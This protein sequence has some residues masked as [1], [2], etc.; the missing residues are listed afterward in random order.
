MFQSP[1]PEGSCS[2]ALSDMLLTALAFEAA[3]QTRALMHLEHTFF[4]VVPIKA[5]ILWFRAGR[6]GVIGLWLGVSTKLNSGDPRIILGDSFR[7]CAYGSICLV[8]SSTCCVW[9][10]AAVSGAVRIL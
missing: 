4:I 5:L 8:I 2:F 1:A 7:Q 9:I 3:Y 10:S 6:L